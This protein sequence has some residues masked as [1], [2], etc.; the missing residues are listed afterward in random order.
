MLVVLYSLTLSLISYAFLQGMV[1]LTYL[2]FYMVMVTLNQNMIL[3]QILIRIL[4]WTLIWILTLNKTL[5]L[6]LTLTE[7]WKKKKKSVV[8]QKI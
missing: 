3:S 7:I 2:F 1:T 6:I 5:T 8:S 4:T